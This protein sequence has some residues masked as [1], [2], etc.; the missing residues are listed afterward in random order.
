LFCVVP[1]VI[2]GLGSLLTTKG[3]AAVGGC[4]L[5]AVKQNRFYDSQTAG[6]LSLF[7]V[8]LTPPAGFFPDLAAKEGKRQLVRDVH[9]WNPGKRGTK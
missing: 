8:F 7:P 1:V 9:D 4:D 5:R 3:S 2:P 6:T